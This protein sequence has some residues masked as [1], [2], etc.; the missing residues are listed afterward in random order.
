M[1][2]TGE[3]ADMLWILE[4]V[5]YVKIYQGEEDSMYYAEVM[6]LS[7]KICIDFYQHTYGALLGDIRHFLLASAEDK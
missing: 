2:V 4:R 7:G 3:T 5:G 1:A 6:Y